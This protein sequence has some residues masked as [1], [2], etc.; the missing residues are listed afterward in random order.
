MPTAAA[1]L[2]GGPSASTRAPTGRASAQTPPESVSE[3]L[4][5]PGAGLSPSRWQPCQAYR[6]QGPAGLEAVTHAHAGARASSQRC[7]MMTRGALGVGFEPSRVV[8]R[9]PNGAAEQAHGH[10]GGEQFF[11]PC[12]HALVCLG[13]GIWTKVTGRRDCVLPL[14]LHA[15][16]SRLARL[17]ATRNGT[18]PTA[19]PQVRRA[20]TALMRRRLEAKFCCCDL[21]DRSPYQA[22]VSLAAAGSVRTQNPFCHAMQIDLRMRVGTQTP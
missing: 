3:A 1:L 11:F 19:S 6:S 20:P 18:R 22:D 9:C 14:P 10:R 2:R 13:S 15:A 7:C 5:L 17:R 8:W 12:G 16:P 4:D 21:S